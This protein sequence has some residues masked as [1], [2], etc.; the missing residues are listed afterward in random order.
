MQGFE[1]K[2]KDIIMSCSGTI[3]KFAIAPDNIEKGIINQALLRFRAKENIVPEYLK[4]CLEHIEDEF[5][6]KSHGLGLQNVMS[7]DNLKLIKIPVPSKLDE[8][9]KIIDTVNE[10]EEKK[11]DLYKKIENERE[12]MSKIIQINN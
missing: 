2:P 3:G 12:K 9:Q 8:Q 1:L 10:F 4:I 5:R 11:L 7:V 6:K